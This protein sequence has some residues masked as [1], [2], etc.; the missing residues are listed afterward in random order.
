MI[1]KVAAS[2]RR[3][4]SSHICVMPM[5]VQSHTVDFFLL[6]EY[7]QCHYLSCDGI[8]LIVFKWL[9]K[10]VQRRQVL[11]NLDADSKLDTT[12]SLD[13]LCSDIGDHGQPYRCQLVLAQV[14]SSVIVDRH[15]YRWSLY[16]NTVWRT[17][18]SNPIFIWKAPVDH[19][20]AKIEMLG[21][22]MIRPFNPSAITTSL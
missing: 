12:F 6:I 22:D 5:M 8:D 14:W 1:S 13:R 21:S 3:W 19:P 11:N 16:A 18:P 2:R 10:G 9:G 17:E 20:L 7:T 15:I 4:G